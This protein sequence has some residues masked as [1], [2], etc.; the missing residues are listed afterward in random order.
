MRGSD[1]VLP[2]TPIAAGVT[3]ARSYRLIFSMTKIEFQ[4]HKLSLA[5]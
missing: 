1:S 3:S 2:D 4:Q 5:S